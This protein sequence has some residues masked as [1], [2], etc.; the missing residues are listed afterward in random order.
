MTR[1]AILMPRPMLPGVIA[2]LEDRFELHRLW[3]R[4]DEDAY[5]AE[6]GRR[7][8]GMAV[9]TLAGRIDESWFDRLPALEVVANFGVGYDNVDVKAA[10]A[11]GIVVTNTPGVLDEEVADLT[12]GLL[13]ATVRRIPQADRYLRA[14]RWTDAPFPLSPT[15]RGRRV[16]ILG[17]GAIGKAVARRLE[18]FGTTVAY[19]GRSRQEDVAYDYHGSPVALAAACD[20]LIILVP[21]GSKTRHLVDGDVLRALG[22][23]GI[24]INVARGSVVD[25]QALIAALRDGTILSAGLDVFENEP[26]V[27]P[28]LSANPDVVLLPHI[29]SASQATRAAMGGL[30]VDN[31]VAWFET[32]RAITPVA[33]TAG[34]AGSQG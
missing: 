19:H 10:A 2:A 7:I 28:E 3:E 12:L 27:P 20:V 33:E 16:G 15:L 23:N 22:P 13:L 6:I 1:P 24:L 8:R 32:G 29:G 18:A 34:D 5:L 21:G 14:G 4:P 25:Q 17:L 26:H 31:L 11:R 9:S 30:V